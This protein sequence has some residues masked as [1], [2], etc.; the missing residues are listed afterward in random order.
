MTGERWRCFAGIPIDDALRAQLR[1]AVERWRDDASLADLRW[2]DPGGWHITLAFLG[3]IAPGS[4]PARVERMAGVAAEHSASTSAADAFGGFPTAA[5]AR[6]AWLG[7]EDAQGRLARLAADL[8]AA[9]SVE[10]TLPFKPH[11]TLARARRGP[12]DLRPWLASASVIDGVLSADRIALMRSHAG[13]GPARYETL[14]MIS[15]GVPARV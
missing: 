8:S 13:S 1:A 3:A 14:A 11:L 15:L 2:T 5:R 12:V 7:F 6:V 10:V 9:L 4:V